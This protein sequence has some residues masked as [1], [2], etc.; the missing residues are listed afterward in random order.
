MK[1]AFTQK[2][3][4]E[5]GGRHKRNR[6]KGGGEARRGRMPEKIWETREGKGK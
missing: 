1:L 6:P 2:G 5:R 3:A 4:E